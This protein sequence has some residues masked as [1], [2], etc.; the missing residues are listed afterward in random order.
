[1]SIAA[2]MFSPQYSCIK[3]REFLHLRRAGDADLCL[4]F[5]EPAFHAQL[6]RHPSKINM[7][8]WENQFRERQSQESQVKPGTV[9]CDHHRI[10]LQSF[11]KIVEIVAVK[12]QLVLSTI[13]QPNDRDGVKH[14]R[15]TCGLDIK[16]NALI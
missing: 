7:H 3:P 2:Q 13:V 11:R 9:E 8:R 10:L 15:Q 14:G 16:V 1:M 5:L 12:E 6:A 4:Y